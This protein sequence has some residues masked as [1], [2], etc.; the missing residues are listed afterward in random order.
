MIIAWWMKGQQHVLDAACAESFERKA[1]W[2]CLQKRVLR[3]PFTGTIRQW[4]IRDGKKV[5]FD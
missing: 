4:V 2:E 1:R 5:Y 3:T